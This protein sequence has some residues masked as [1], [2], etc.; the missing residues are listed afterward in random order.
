MVHSPAR[1]LDVGSVIAG[2]Y[3]I[4]GLIGKGGMGAVFIASHARLPG[5]KVA[6]KVLHPD[7]AD[8]DSQARSRDRVAPRPSQYRRGS[9][10]EPAP[11]WDAV[12]RVRAARR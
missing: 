11:G 3:T 1:A 5:K 7:V 8:G 10:L 6:I 4:E 9:R 12:H 2:T